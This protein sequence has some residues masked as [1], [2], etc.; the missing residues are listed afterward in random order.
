MSRPLPGSSL[1]ISALSTST[2]PSRLFSPS[3]GV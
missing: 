1:M 3:V 2:V